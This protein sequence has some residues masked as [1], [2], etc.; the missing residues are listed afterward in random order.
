MATEAETQ[1]AIFEWAMWNQNL[2]PE[3]EMMYAVPNGQYRP[4]QRLEPGT[5][6]GVPDICLPVPRGDYHG[7]YLEL[8]VGK[9]RATE[10]QVWW[11]DNLKAQGYY[12]VCAHGFDTAIAAI[13]R[14]LSLPAA[15]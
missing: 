1:Q 11:L 4:G 2:V 10:S 3:L 13:E 15:E 5:R 12:T 14:Y 6:S 8:K 9:N 7:M